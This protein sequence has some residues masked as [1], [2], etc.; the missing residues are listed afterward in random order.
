MANNYDFTY[1]FNQPTIRVPKSKLLKSVICTVDITYSG[2]GW[3]GGK[4]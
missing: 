1:C 3:F 2:L 4:K